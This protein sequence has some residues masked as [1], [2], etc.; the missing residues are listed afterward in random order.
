MSVVRYDTRAVL[1]GLPDDPYGAVGL[2]IYATAAFAFSSLEEGARRF[3]TGEGYTY[4]RAQNP[5]NRALEERLA[6]LEGA[7]DAA[8]FASGQAATL[9]AVIALVQ[10]GDEIVAATGLFGQT[11]GL[12]NHVLGLMGINVHYVPAERDAVAEVLSDRTRAIFVETLSNPDLSIPDFEGIAALAE[13]HGI[14]FIVD[15][16]FGAVGAL[17][18][19][20][21]LGAH[22]VVE[23]LTKWASGHGSVLG[24]AVLAR[25]TDLW[26]RYAPYTTPDAEGKTLWSTFGPQAYMA[27]VR[28]LG[29]S[30]MGMVLSPFHAYLIFQGLET[31]PLRV[32]R[33]SRT[34]MELAT[35]LQGHPKVLKVRC[36]ALPEDPSHQR[37]K[38]YFRAFGTLLTIEVEEGSEGAARVLEKCRL[39][40]APNVG[41]VRTLVVHPWTTTHGR[42][43]EPARL[44]AGVKPGLIRISVGLEDPEDLKAWLGE[45]LG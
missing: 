15:N 19:P 39:L 25:R 14:A 8:V 13:A 45:C 9:A 20:L 43:S 1:S 40:Q 41:D 5:T 32:E 29:L 12:F 36:P 16:T 18:R 30:L 28:Q 34:A 3:A 33:A 23:S 7:A 44:K 31:L 24:G 11:T 21:T 26:Q 38:R 35:F 27:R 10:A 6:A 2:P 17:A 22:V 4:S 42:L 37:A